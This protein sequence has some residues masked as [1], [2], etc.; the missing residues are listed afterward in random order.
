M[1]KLML[2]FAALILV[3]GISAQNLQLHFDG[4]HGL[5]SDVA[6][7]NYITATFEMFKPDKWGSTF[8]FVDLDFNQSR[9]NIGTMYLEIARDIKVGKSP[10]M[11]HL[12]FNGGIGK[13][14]DFGFS[15]P[16]AYLVGPSYNRNFGSVNI[17]T[18]LV[19]KYNA[20]EKVSND[21][22]WTVTWGTNLLNN[23]ITLSG[24][25]DLWTENKNKTHN[26]GDSGKKVILL[27]EPQFW[28][29]VTPNLSF[30][31]EIE[32]SNNFYTNYNNNVYVCPTLAAKWNF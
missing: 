16:N 10:I 21:V 13:A 20:F 28:Y 32:I 12:E 19:Y 30:G 14:E 8:M 25:L 4:R 3:A 18:Y 22:Q 15:I 5:H 31:S 2:L 9:G 7:R 26:N 24:F 1:K 27:T 11:A 29:N 6:P 17:G 23:K